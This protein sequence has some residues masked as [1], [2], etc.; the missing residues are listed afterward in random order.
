MKAYLFCMLLTCLVAGC[1]KSGGGSSTP[2][3][4]ASL[5]FTTNPD[6]GTSIF[7]ALSSSQDITISITSALPAAGVTADIVVT[8]DLD[9]S[10]VFSQSL[11]NTSPNFIVTIQSLPVGTICN[12]LITLTSKST[13]SN[14]ASKSFKIARK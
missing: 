8:K 6:P 13:V 4:E 2:A 3:Q 1:G 12:V 14:K 7:P 5:V 9:N 10:T 11:T